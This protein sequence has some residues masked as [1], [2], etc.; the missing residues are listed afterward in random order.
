[1]C[2]CIINVS[3]YYLGSEGTLFLSGSAHLSN[4]QTVLSSVVYRND[5]FEPST[6]NR[7]ITF[8]VNDNDFDSNIA[9]LTISISLVNDNPLA[10]SCAPS[11]MNY[12]ENRDSQGDL[13]RPILN[14]YLFDIYCLTVEPV[15]FDTCLIRNYFDP[16]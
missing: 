15:S 1:M 14:R 3:V 7:T 6:M 2:L 16:T 12:T 11:F 5:R 10:I 9:S 8:V 4:Y 13:L